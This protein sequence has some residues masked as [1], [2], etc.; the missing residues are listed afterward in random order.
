MDAKSPQSCQ[1]R[2]HGVEMAHRM[3]NRIL[4]MW[5]SDMLELRRRNLLGLG[6]PQANSAESGADPEATQGVTRVLPMNEAA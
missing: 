6:W 4:V 2:E 3:F 1:Q 5:A